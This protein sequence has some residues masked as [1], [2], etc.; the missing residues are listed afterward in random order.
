MLA[1]IA[2][3]AQAEALKAVR[4]GVMCASAD[5]LAAL[6][7]P[8]GSSR[9]DSGR[10]YAAL[11]QRG[12]CFDLV[13]GDTV[14]VMQMR[15]NTSIV[16]FNGRFG[17]PAGTYLIATIDFAPGSAPP[18]EAGAA[19][20]RP[21]PNAPPPSLAP[22]LAAQSAHP[23]AAWASPP[24]PP[25]KLAAL[26]SV[27]APSPPPV[28]PVIPPAAVPES[29]DEAASSAVLPPDP[30]RSDKPAPAAHAGS[31]PDVSGLRLG[32]TPAEARKTFDPQLT[33]Q[34]RN[35]SDPDR[36]AIVATTNHGLLGGSEAYEA[37]LLEFVYGQLA[38]VHHAQV[39]AAGSEPLASAVA[40]A[41]RAKYGRDYEDT[42]REPDMSWSRNADDQPIDVRQSKGCLSAPEDRVPLRGLVTQGLST[43]YD[44]G[45]VPKA[46]PDRMQHA[47]VTKLCG[48]ILLAEQTRDP[49]DGAL[50]KRLDVMLLDAGAFFRLDANRAAETQVTD[51]AAKQA[52]KINQ[53]HL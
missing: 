2:G 23:S 25:Q 48:R 20:A 8:D 17:V 24:S 37:Y 39:F 1:S 22:P 52:A 9:S 13:P 28:Y 49:V 6:T 42:T 46:G 40:A 51:Q 47:D 29:H 34:D 3:G 36:S 19:P 26:K 35:L 27:P 30:P 11:K 31:V 50:V 15:H 5:A 16:Q 53:L 4:P 21:A 7:R 38:Y 33:I 12:G 43:Q 18:P 14:T 44:A 32:M 45:L 41:L 10:A